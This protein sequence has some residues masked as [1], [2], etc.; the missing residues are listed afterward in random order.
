MSQAAWLVTGANRGLGLGLVK[1][2]REIGEDVIG[3]CRD[4]DAA[5]ELRGVEGIRIEALDVTSTE[6]CSALLQRLAEDS[7]KLR[8]IIN[9]AGLLTKSFAVKEK[10]DSGEEVDVTY[11]YTAGVFTLTP[12]LFREHFM[13]NAMGAFSVT[14]ALRTL[15]CEHNGRPPVIANVS[16]MT[17]SIEL[18]RQ[19]GSNVAGYY[20]V[21]KTAL[22]MVNM[23]M[24]TALPQAICIVLQPGWVKTDMGGPHAKVEASEAAAGIV[25]V[26]LETTLQH[27]GKFYD[28]E[29]KELPW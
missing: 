2:L 20:R 19:Y 5:A 1:R 11:D 6:S 24:A 21:S 8:G 7:V 14:K 25:T 29:G 18:T 4:V 27:S 9:N 26:L 12:L 17:G 16:S 23:L 22:N 28:Y 15:L 3:T 13:V 10:N